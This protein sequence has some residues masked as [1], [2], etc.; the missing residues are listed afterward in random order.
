MVFIYCIN[1]K[2]GGFI[3][4]GGGDVVGSVKV[5]EG[6]R[7]FLLCR[8]SVIISYLVEV[9]EWLW[10]G[11]DEGRVISCCRDGVWR[12]GDAGRKV[13]NLWYGGQ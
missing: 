10:D 9:Y 13:I 3:N 2:F 5:L 11:K 1:Y 12:C 7:G 8:S 4:L 6:E